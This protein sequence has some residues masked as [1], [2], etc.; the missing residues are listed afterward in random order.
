MVNEFLAQLDGFNADNEGVLVL[1]ATNMPWD[2]DSAMKRPGRFT[3]QVFVAPPDPVAQNVLA[4]EHYATVLDEIMV[5]AGIL[6]HWVLAGT[7]TMDLRYRRPVAGDDQIGDA[8]IDRDAVQRGM[9]LDHPPVRLR[10]Q[11]RGDGV[12][13]LDDMIQP[14]RQP[15]ER[16]RQVGGLVDQ[17][18]RDHLQPGRAVLRAAA[19]HDVAVAKVEAVP[20]AAVFIRRHIPASCSHPFPSETCREYRH[21]RV[22]LRVKAVPER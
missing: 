9:G 16:C 15:P 4:P 17:Q 10:G 7:G 5:W 21:R 8:R 12:A 20:T 2:V 19:D 18:Q 1:A 3:R 6:S 22:P 13:G 11:A 14:W